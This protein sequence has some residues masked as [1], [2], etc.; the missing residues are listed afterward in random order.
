MMQR[1]RRIDR[2][3]VVDGALIA[4]DEQLRDPSPMVEMGC[5]FFCLHFEVEPEMKIHKESNNL[6]FLNCG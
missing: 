4:F 5:Q 2:Y 6:S 1:W 3:F